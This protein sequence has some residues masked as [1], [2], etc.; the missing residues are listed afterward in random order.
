M[1]SLSYF[2]ILF[3]SNVCWFSLNSRTGFVVPVCSPDQKEIG[4]EKWL[5]LKAPTASV[6]TDGTLVSKGCRAD[7]VETEF[8]LGFPGNEVVV[9]PPIP[10]C[11]RVP[12]EK[13]GSKTLRS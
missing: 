5:W 12:R 11:V 3:Q 9:D 7:I 10:D 13:N 6:G 4:I 2:A 1:Y 8:P